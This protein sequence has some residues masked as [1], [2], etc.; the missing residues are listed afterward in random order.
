MKTPEELERAKELERLYPNMTDYLAVVSGIFSPFDHIDGEDG[1][2][3]M[4]D[5]ECWC[6]P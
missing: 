2:C 6:H 4:V 5:C 1:R 3:M